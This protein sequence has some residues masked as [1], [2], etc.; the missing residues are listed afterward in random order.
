MQNNF[1]FAYNFMAPHE[2]THTNFLSKDPND[3]GG[4]TKYGISKRAYPDLD[5]ENLTKE[6]AKYLTWRDYWEKTNLDLINSKEVGASL[7]DFF[8][9]SGVDEVLR[10]QKLLRNEFGKNISLDRFLGPQTATAINSI[11]PKEFGISLNN[12]R[13]K[14]LKSLK[15]WDSFK[16]GFTKRLEDN[17]RLF[18]S[19]KKK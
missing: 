15:V 8:F 1:E 16:N 9:H 3:P 17:F 7:L 2:Y 12:T 14:Y 13:L 4:V 5:I 6:E 10:I 19:E 18:T 11:N